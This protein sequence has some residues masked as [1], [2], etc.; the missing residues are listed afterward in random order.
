MVTETRP[1]SVLIV[2]D[3]ALVRRTIR[4]SLTGRGFVCYEAENAANAM[5]SL[6]RSPAE[7]V[8]LDIRMPG[9]TG[10]ELLPEISATFPETAVIMATADIEPSSN[11]LKTAPRT[12]S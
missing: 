12:T 2:D 5:E 7:V 8:L 6:N 4:K 10:K 9:K 11:V 3:E 1:S